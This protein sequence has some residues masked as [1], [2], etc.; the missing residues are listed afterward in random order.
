MFVQPF[1]EICRKDLNPV[2]A[3]TASKNK[4]LHGD[5][6]IC[7]DCDSFSNRVETVWSSGSEHKIV[8]PRAEDD[9]N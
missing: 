9:D 2:M 8:I 6:H 1:C 3:I 5:C 4:K 7:S